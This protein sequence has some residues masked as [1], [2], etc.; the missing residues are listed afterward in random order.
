MEEPCDRLVAE[1]RASEERYRS[2]TQTAVDAVMTTDA[3]GT[4]LTWNRGAQAM[5][6]LGP[7]MVGQ[8]VLAIIP[9]RFRQAHEEGVRRFLASGRRVL[10]D[11]VAELSALRG[12]GSEFP[13]ELSLSTWEGAEGVCFGAIIR[14]ISER[15]R[16]ERLREDVQR[17]IRHDLKSPLVGIVGLAG[18]LLKS[19]GLDERQRRSA[20][21]IQ[22]LGQRLLG[23]IQRSRDMFQLEE[24]TYQLTPGPVDLLAILRQA[25]L[26]LAGLARGRQVEMALRLGD[27]PATEAD[28]FLV[29]GEAG[30]LAVL[31][32]NLLKNAIEA[33]PPDSE[34]TAVLKD[35]GPQ[36]RLLD[37]H[38]LGEVPPEVRPRFFEPYVTSG[39]PEG[40]GLGTHSARLITLAHGGEIS[41]T[42]SKTKGTHLLVRL[43]APPA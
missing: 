7:E 11:K 13:I 42:T 38:N 18:L 27:V 19:P 15:K 29:W 4:I 31:V 30:L 12:D 21:G 5:F 6:G 32:E 10:L 14:D 33:A 43:P 22:E 3:A 28:V 16:V 36:G 24:G 2:V 25:A 9:E 34:V 37:L 23:F 17:M 39:K 41:F 20:H 1:L 26:E 35:L 40:T 8:S